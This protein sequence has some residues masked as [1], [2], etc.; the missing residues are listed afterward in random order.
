MY[1]VLWTLYIS[2]H[3]H[4]T[5]YTLNI[6][7]ATVSK[8]TYNYICKTLHIFQTCYQYFTYLTKKIYSVFLLIYSKLV[9]TL[10]IGYVP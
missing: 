10:G 6:D 4:C 8:H 1:T 9:C 5:V 3:L 7:K 2:V